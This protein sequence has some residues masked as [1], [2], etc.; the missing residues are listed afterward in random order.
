VPLEAVLLTGKRNIVYVKVS[1]GHFEAREVQVGNRIDGRY[2][3]LSGLS[4]GEEVASSGG[5]LI[6]S[7]SQLRGINNSEHKH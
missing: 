3:I 1:A 7:E 5:Y 6:D 4:S 2:E